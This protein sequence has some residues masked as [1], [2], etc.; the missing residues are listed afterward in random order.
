MKDIQKHK[1]RMA[2]LRKFNEKSHLK[3]IATTTVQN[4]FL[5]EEA[6]PDFLNKMYVAEAYSQRIDNFDLSVS[7]DQA[8]ALIE[9]IS[10]DQ[11]PMDHILEPVFLSLF[12]GT[13]RAFKLGTKQG[14]TASRLY[15]ECKA[16]TYK[17]PAANSTLDSYTESLNEQDN[18]REFGKT[19]S[20]QNGE[21]TRDGENTNMRDGSKMKTA[22]EEHFGD[23]HSATDGYNSGQEIFKEKGL[24]KS[25]GTPEQ[26]A[27]V[28]H[29]TP[30]AEVCASL[31]SNKA[32]NPEDIKEIINT[33][34]N[35]VV[36]S[37]QNN[38]G[39][40]TGKFAKSRDE[41]QQELDQGYV[42]DK[43][44]NKHPLSEE[45]RQSRE[46]MVEKME[47]A[48]AEID[49]KTNEKVVDN[50][51]HDRKTQTR[52]ASD[53]GNAAANQSIGDLIIF[54]IK[55]LYYELSDCF[56]NGI[57]KGVN[58]SSFK[59]ALSIRINR[60]KKH[61]V[62]QAG[63]MLKDGMLGFFKNFLS[64]LLEG[65][66]NCFVGVFKNVIRIMKEGFKALLQIIPILKDTNT[67]AAEK[68]DAILKLIAGSL[69][70]FASL[71]IETWLNSI[72][73]GE[74][75]SIIITSVLSAVLTT[76]VMYLLD[77]LDLF[78]AKQEL[79]QRRINEVLKLKIEDTEEEILSLVKAYT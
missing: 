48:Q 2:R 6:D 49:D 17:A 74:P 14:I 27:E 22:K 64:M 15:A 38:R 59:S 39:T 60:M 61:I 25:R 10:V 1:A 3:P 23:S 7:K 26:S 67:P 54:M 4:K 63:N 52:L 42:V 35:L 62:D 51:K 24:A 76:S 16:F 70:I 32:L 13:M 41:L 21:L 11:H 36:T 50:L 9:S 44:G 77:K 43:K 20:Y 79:K 73:I 30:C 19:S 68:G 33:D 65:I 66:V 37:Q 40:N 75:W 78:G 71:G 69:T 53:A 47:I 46:N 5:Q 12:D 58:A 28:D 31:Q 18:I 72:G 55:P 34:A 8:L 56:T 45:D 57:E 29:A